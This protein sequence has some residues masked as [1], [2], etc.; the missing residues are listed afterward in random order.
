MFIPFDV[1]NYPD[2]KEQPM[3]FKNAIDAL[4]YT[5]LVELNRLSPNPMVHILAKLGGAVP[6]SRT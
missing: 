4:G 5:P 1:I 6:A 3:Y 2:I